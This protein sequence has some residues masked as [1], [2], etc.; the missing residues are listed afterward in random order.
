M[1]AA[2][3]NVVL[4]EAQVT[5]VLSALADS[6]GMN[7][8]EKSAWVEHCVLAELRGNIM[9]SF[10]NIERHF[11]S[12]FLDGQVKFG[13]K[14]RVLKKTPAMA[15]LDA[16]GALGPYAGKYAMEFAC[17]EAEQTGA[18]VVTLR[19]CNDWC[20]TSYSTRQAL[21]YGCIGI[22]MANSRPQFAPWGGTTA[23]YG[24][25][26]LSI[27]IPTR[28]HYPV[29]ID[30][31]ASDT[32]GRVG[33]TQKHRDGLAPGGRYYDENG[34]LLADPLPMG[35][36]RVGP[37]GLAER[38][39]SYRDF[40][41]AVG[42]DSIAGALSGMQTALALATIEPAVNG[43]RV[44][45]G[46]IVIALHVEHFT[47]LDEFQTKVDRAIDE[48]K[49]SPP[50]KGFAEVFMPG[51]RGYR[52]EERRRREGIP[53]F[54]RVWDRLKRLCDSRGIDLSAIVSGS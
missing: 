40:A 44:P 12:R 39:S 38:M 53:I 6:F 47:S 21:R 23:V 32:G 27:A 9:Q 54:D 17:S 4:T 45:R 51:E 41:L 11:V 49:S 52:E 3:T 28:R 35:S 42:I 13:A 1:Q 36:F 16:D 22:A 50:A 48:A 30:M 24:M 43:V 34:E 18:F 33:Q 20:M 2:R 31:G 10:A 29:L 19:N 15:V 7:E 37:G 26:G 25:N 46:Q 14:I 8:A 5:A